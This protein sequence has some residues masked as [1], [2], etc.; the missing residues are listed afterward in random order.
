V[1]NVTFELRDCAG[2]RLPNQD[3][4]LSLVPS[5]GGV[6]IEGGTGPVTQRTNSLGQVTVRINSGTV[7]TPVRVLATVAST[8]IQT[9]SSGLS[10][11]VG[12]PSQVN[13]SLSQVTPNIEG[14]NL[15]G[16]TNTYSI[17]ASD[18]S[19]NPVP[20]GTSINFVTESGQIEAIKQTQTVQGLSRT[21]ANFVSSSPRPADGRF[22]VTVYALGEESFLDLNGNN[23]YD[24][25]E[26]F[27]DLGDVFKDRSFDGVFNPSIDESISLGITGTSACAAPGSALLSLDVS[28]PSIPGTC[29]SVW[30]RTYVRRS[31]ETV[32]STSSSDP[33]WVRD[34]EP[35]SPGTPVALATSPNS[36]PITYHRVIG[37]SITGVGAKGTLAFLVRDENLVRLNP[38]AA[39]TTITATATTGLTLTVAGSPVPNTTE[40]SPA[41][42]GYEFGATTASGTITITI[43]S[44]SGAGTVFQ[45]PIVKQ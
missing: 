14:F 21:G 18:R 3:M 15:D 37:S 39:G 31:I 7:P 9:V 36:S 8:G 6:T 24:P 30:G 11:G 16:T 29:N 10:I 22:T 42:I 23:V 45:I 41:A 35:A 25:G 2:N 4:V 26:P 1:S 38:M 17:I 12:L 28:I 40:A 27:Q 20:N 19:G 34:S 5:A 33:V 13:F 43:R 44:P 32:L